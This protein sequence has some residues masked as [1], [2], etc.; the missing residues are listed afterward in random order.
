MSFKE[1]LQARYPGRVVSVRPD[2]ASASFI[3]FQKR[4]GDAGGWSPC[5]EKHVIPNGILLPGYN[6]QP[7]VLPPVR[8]SGNTFF[9][10]TSD[11]TQSSVG[12]SNAPLSDNAVSIDDRS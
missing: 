4:D 12:A 8:D 10:P 3:A 1:A 5:W 7:V 6:N 11:S 2:S 9:G